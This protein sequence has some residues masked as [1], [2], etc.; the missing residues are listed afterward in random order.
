M[1]QDP[2]HDEEP[3]SSEDTLDISHDLDMVPVFSS[4]TVD[5]EMEGDLICG[6]LA[7]TGIP[8]LLSRSTFP[9]LG[10]SVRVPRARLEEA[11]RL[12]AE[13]QA[14]GPE[15]AAEAERASE[16]ER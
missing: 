11:Q 9:N 13:A 3:V 14:A 1:A 6:V 4:A 8:A 16:G 7:D 10:V 12:I 5:A 15:A 2:E